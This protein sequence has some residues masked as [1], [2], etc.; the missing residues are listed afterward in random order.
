[1]D[2]GMLLRVVPL[3]VPYW[4][5]Q[6]ISAVASGH[7]IEHHEHLKATVLVTHV[8]VLAASIRFGNCYRRHHSSTLLLMM[9]SGTLPFDLEIDPPLAGVKMVHLMKHAHRPSEDR[10]TLDT[11]TRSKAPAGGPV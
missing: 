7:K 11:T 5:R 1:M 8:L 10:A 3:N 4:I 9:G 6:S 2:R